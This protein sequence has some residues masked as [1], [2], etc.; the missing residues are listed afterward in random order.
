MGVVLVAESWL[1]KELQIGEIKLRAP[2]APECPTCG[3]EFSIPVADILAV[4]TG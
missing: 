2:R 3:H 4:A 1:Q